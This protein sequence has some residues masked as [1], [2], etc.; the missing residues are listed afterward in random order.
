MSEI[1]IEDY[2][3]DFQDPAALPASVQAT[4]QAA[5]QAT[6]APQD[7]PIEP[8]AASRGRRPSRDAAARTSGRRTTPSPPP[9]RRPP[10]S[11]ASSY[12]SALSS[13]PAK[14]KWTVVGL[15]QALA[16]S[17]VIIPRR[18]TKADLL[19]LYASLQAEENPGSAPPSRA[20]GGARTSRCAP[21]ARPEQSTTPPKTASRP[22]G[23][24]EGPSASRGHA[25]KAAV[26][27]HCP[28]SRPSE[29]EL[30]AHTG[31]EP[32]FASTSRNSGAS[33]PPPA[34]ISPPLSS[35][36]MSIP[37][38][39]AQAPVP[40]IPPL[41]PSLSSAP[42]AVPSV[43]LPFT[44]HALMPAI[45]PLLP[46]LSS[47]PGAVPSVSLPLTTH[48]PTPAIPPLF[49][50]FSSFPQNAHSASMPPPA[51]P[52]AFFPPQTR[53]PFSLA[54]ATPLPAPPNAL[55][56]EPPPV[57]NSIRTQI[58][59][60]IQIAGTRG[61]PAPDPGSSLFRTDIPVNHPLRPLLEASIN[62]ILQ[63]VSPRTL[64]AYLTAWK[65]FKVFHSAY[66]LPFPDFS[67]LAVTSFI[68]HLNTNKNLQASSIKGYLSG[69][70]FFHKLLYGSPSPHITN[71]QTSLLIKGIQKTQPNRPDPRQP[72]TLKILT[73]CISTLRKGYH[74]I[75]TARTLDA[76]F[77]L[78]FF[79]FLRCSEL[80][81]T[82]GFN[83]AIHPT[84]SDLAVLDG[85]TI[86]YFIKQSKTDQ[87]K[88]GHFI[89]I[90]N[91][92]S[93]I[94]PFQ[95]LLAFLQLRKSQ[96]KLPSDPLFTDDF[97]RPAT[98]F[99]FQKHLKS[100]LLLSGTPADNF[101]SHSFRIG[102]A[103]TAAQKGLSQQQ[104][105]ALG[106]WSSEA[107]KSYIR[108]DR[109]LIKEVHQTLQPLFI[110]LQQHHIPTSTIP[111]ASYSSRSLSLLPHTAV[112]VPAPA[113]AP[114]LPPL[115]RSR[116]SPPPPFFVLPTAAAVPAP[117]GALFSV[118]LRRFF[119]I[120]S[121][122][123][124]QELLP[125]FPVY[126]LRLRPASLQPK[127]SIFWG[128]NWL[129]AYWV[130]AKCRARTPLPRQGGC[131]GFGNDFRARSP[132]PD[133]T[134]NTLNLNWYM[135]EPDSPTL[136]L[137]APRYQLKNGGHHNH[138]SLWAQ[139]ALLLLRE[140]SGRC[141]N[142]K[143]QTLLHLLSNIQKCLHNKREPSV[144]VAFSI[145]VLS[146]D[147][148]SKAFSSRTAD[149]SNLRPI[150]ATVLNETAPPNFTFM[151][152]CRAVRRGI[153]LKGAPQILFIII[154]R[155]PKYS[156]AFVEDTINDIRLNSDS[157]KISVLVLLDLSAAFDTRDW[158][159]GWFRSYL[160]GRG[161]YVGIGEHQSNLYMLP[162]SQ[163]MS[164]NQIAYHS[165]A[166]DTQ[167]YLSLSP[168]DYSPIDS[169]CQ[170]I[171][172][173]NS[174]MCQNFLQLNKEKTEVIAF[175]SKEE[176][177]KVNAYL[178]SRGHTTKNQVRNLGV[179]LESDL[180]FSSHVKAVTKSAYYHRKNIARI[181][182]FVSSQ[183][184]EK[185]VHAFITSRVDYCN[186][187]LTGLPKKTIRQLQLIQNAAARI[188][189]RTRKSEYITPVLRSL[190]WLPVIF[191]I[192][193]KVL[194]LIYKSLNGLGPKY[195]ADM[196]TEYK[197]NR[198]LRSL[199]SSQ[200]EIPRVHTKQGESAFSH[201]AARSW[202]QLPEEI[203]WAKTLAT[204]KSRLKTH[205]FSCAFTE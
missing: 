152:V 145:S 84:I 171:D 138:Q 124:L 91:L 136:L 85:E 43:S 193:F 115:A 76:M 187:L 83:P 113:G 203:K 199:G 52:A 180:S 58:L 46:S 99:W 96:S 119:H 82:S 36:S 159:T 204:F 72:I 108:S 123:C 106:R 158:K 101:S 4:D 28:P 105:Q 147:R 68:S 118:P 39:T 109:S 195:I 141:H 120:L 201:Y 19:T 15:R 111:S 56:L 176:V 167:I 148:K 163:I 90:F 30:A 143:A 190:H 194:L 27:S 55:A 16:S 154:Y 146:R 140:L 95:A 13:A 41:F 49:P 62:S 125:Y 38:P 130:R 172:E 133:S 88:K 70:Q 110:S 142:A 184:L 14:A 77:I 22:S 202:N 71:S 186:G 64:Q 198:P 104:I 53:P 60:E 168:N 182:C 23:R 3:S 8:A 47:A 54:S 131:P 24:S 48:A 112:A 166:D 137:Q 149:P 1:E 170:C 127:L 122:Q 65:C 134:P 155:P 175:G 150:S 173:I 103:T 97:N 59:A 20:S 5:S 169:L 107:F 144:P 196:L 26:A 51:V 128:V 117:A 165:Y 2:S 153:V 29:R 32:V 73:K 33:P 81:I 57:P 200:L 66:S 11:P 79:G 160:E 40:P 6:S 10:P 31:G 181:R 45:P 177:L 132:L 7:P 100:V 178:D 179:I 139:L 92:Q 188:L 34:A 44:T 135:L 67:L 192:D 42:G 197:P 161:Y 98:R 151:S 205:L 129:L 87:T 93:P 157:G 191:R 9:S 75:H 183:D 69:I 17:G 126:A 114:S 94:Q 74:S 21:Y 12:A 80:A 116:W 78:A 50:P 185:L 63:A 174:W 18:S 89:Y 121:Q 189:T 164:K 102:A 156:P 37:P 61:G 25:P 86:S 35:H 162:L